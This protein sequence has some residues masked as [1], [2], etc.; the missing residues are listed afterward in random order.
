L[1]LGNWSGVR[2]ALVA[3]SWPILVVAW[4]AWRMSRLMAKSQEGIAAV[5]GGIAETLMLLVGPPVLLVAL[6]LSLRRGTR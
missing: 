4:I 3:V 1:N 5:S 2:V 6:W